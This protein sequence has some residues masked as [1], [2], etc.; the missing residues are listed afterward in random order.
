[1]KTFP[2]LFAI[3]LTILLGG[4]A[5]PGSPR[6]PV[7]ST[8]AGDTNLCVVYL[9]YRQSIAG[10]NASASASVSSAPGASLGAN[11]STSWGYIAYIGNCDDMASTAKPMTIAGPTNGA[12]PESAPAEKSN[13]KKDEASD[14]KNVVNSANAVTKN[15]VNALKG[16]KGKRHASR[17]I[18]EA[19]PFYEAVAQYAQLRPY[20]EKGN[21]LSVKSALA[22]LRAIANEPSSAPGLTAAPSMNSA[23]VARISA[24]P[25]S[26][27]AKA[28]RLKRHTQ[29]LVNH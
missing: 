6:N 14:K 22:S 13:D 27:L 16:E 24:T 11:A 2:L 7:R 20:Q 3:S 8:R 5:A 21:G 26:I 28:R 1:M 15:I 12:K 4:C 10:T 19:L 29:E 23:D 17:V 9:P 25:E 18:Q